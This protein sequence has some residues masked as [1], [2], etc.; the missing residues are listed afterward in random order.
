MF[1][2]GC[3]GSG[4]GADGHHAVEHNTKAV[5]THTQPAEH[6]GSLL[7]EA[8]TDGP[9]HGED[10]GL[11]ASVFSGLDASIIPMPKRPASRLK[12][13]PHN[14]AWKTPFQL[15]R[16]HADHFQ[17]KTKTNHLAETAKA[18]VQGEEFETATE[19]ALLLPDRSAD[20]T[21]RHV[22]RNAVR[23]GNSV[24]SGWLL[25]VARWIRNPEGRA[26]ATLQ[27][28]T[29][30]AKSD[31]REAAL[32]SIRESMGLI[33]ERP[34]I[35]VL[36]EVALAQLLVD[37]KEEALATARL[38]VRLIRAKNSD[39]LYSSSY[40]RIGQV[41]VRAGELQEVK[42]L[43]KSGGNL[44]TQST[45]GRLRV[46]LAV[47]MA[48][49]GELA[50]SLEW[51][52]QFPRGDT[53]KKQ[54]KQAAYGKIAV[55]LARQGELKQAMQVMS[56]AE[57]QLRFSF[58]TA[59]MKG[60]MAIA[61]ATAGKIQDALKLSRLRGVGSKKVLLAISAAQWD[62][63]QKSEARETLARAE[64][65][66]DCLLYT[67]PSPRDRGCSRMPSSA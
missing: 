57:R 60:D 63:G 45:A 16:F 62:S 27:V 15:A 29:M 10:T 24:D 52:G 7:G 19:L 23:K 22:V 18:L 44:F 40:Q 8:L 31:A 53:P 3:D 47:M 4:D 58:T 64:K 5:E 13:V 35:G 46:T 41:F 65:A 48:D 38:A 25:K 33:K 66:G 55:S 34:R 30:L 67:S 12:A 17:G 6:G 20:F 43:P 14:E 59:S 26:F 1:L 28:A 32:D 37:K 49:E 21:L 39:I 9:V 54:N 36:A 11:D 56:L 42:R 51:I 61:M 50:S 2:L